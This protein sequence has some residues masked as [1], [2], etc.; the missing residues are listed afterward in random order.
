M[1]INR[2]SPYHYADK[3]SSARHYAETL[4]FRST[5]MRVI[6]LQ[7]AT[8]QTNWPP[9]RHYSSSWAFSSAFRREL[10]LRL[11]NHADKLAFSSPLRVEMCL[12]LSTTYTEKSA[13]SLPHHRAMDLQLFTT[14]IEKWAFCLTPCSE[15]AFSLPAHREVCHQLDTIQR[16]SGLQLYTMLSDCLRLAIK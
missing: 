13:F 10:G 16:K 3:I 6:G 5:L 12:Q 1:Q 4:A 9:A 14:Y 11:A 8:T 7:L 15:I 2:L